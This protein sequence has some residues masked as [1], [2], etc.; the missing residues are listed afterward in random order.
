MTSLDSIKNNIRRLYNTHPDIHINVSLSSPRISLTDEPVVITG[1][2]PH[3]FQIEEQGSSLPRRRHT[4]QY[5]DVLT[6]RITIAELDDAEA[7]HK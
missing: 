6:R 1:V 2:Y 4:L 5:T 7:A 3:V